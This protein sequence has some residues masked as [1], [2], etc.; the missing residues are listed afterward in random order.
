MSFSKNKS[1]YMTEIGDDYI[2]MGKCLGI[3]SFGSVDLARDKRS[4]KTYAIK[5]ILKNHIIENGM[6]NQVRKEIYILKNLHHPNIVHI[7]EVLSSPDSLYIVMEYVSGG[8]LYNLIALYGSIPESKCIKYTRQICDALAFCHKLNICH[9]DIKPQNILID[10]NDDIRLIDFGFASIMEVDNI[11]TSTI[12]RNKKNNIRR[13]QFDGIDK[14]DEF[15]RSM[16]SNSVVMKKMG[17]I[18]GTHAYMAPEILSKNTYMAD[19]TDIWAFGTVVFFLL[20]GRMPFSQ[21]DEKKDT[22]TFPQNIN[23]DA[24]DFIRHMLNVDPYKRYSAQKLLDHDWIRDDSSNDD[25]FVRQTIQLS[26]SDN[27]SRDLL[28]SDTFSEEEIGSNIKV[29][30]PD[31]IDDIP[32]FISNVISVLENDTHKWSTRVSNNILNISTITET[33]M[34]LVEI[35]VDGLIIHINNSDTDIGIPISMMNHIHNVV[36]TALSV[37]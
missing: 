30:L 26:S 25:D 35:M 12:Q 19:K 27:T 29:D 8:E 21:G 22:Y 10:A 14:E 11:S 28:I 36:L 6:G 37:I 23:S 16:E 24:Q 5:R 4:N 34:V 17:T 32:D 2:T 20:I 7:R 9:R 3:G 15:E 33:G 13:M 18:C 31:V 1:D